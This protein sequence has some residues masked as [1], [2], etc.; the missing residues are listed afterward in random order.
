VKPIL[1]F[2][3]IA[4]SS[5]AFAQ[6]AGS[7]TSLI[8]FAESGNDFLRICDSPSEQIGSV[9]GAC[10]G[11]VQGVVEGAAVI[12]DHFVQKANP[13]AH[14]ICLGSEVTIGQEYR[15]VVKFIKDHPE[16]SDKATPYLIV[17]AMVGAFPCKAD[18]K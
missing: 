7:P 9:S 1:M 6:T 17:E 8:N 13:A 5:A 3:L 14:F 10:T 16:K 15:V 12:G 4:A 18:A 2:L 11:Y